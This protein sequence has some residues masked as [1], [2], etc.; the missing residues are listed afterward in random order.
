MHPKKKAPW[1]CTGRTRKPSAPSVTLSTHRLGMMAR[2]SVFARAA[3]RSSPMTGRSLGY[4]GTAS[5]I[6]QLRTARALLDQ[7]THALEDAHRLGKIGTWN[8]RLDTR[9][10]GMVA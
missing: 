8:H 1:P 2:G 5:D 10:N 7:R 9:P 6:T 4:R 3:S